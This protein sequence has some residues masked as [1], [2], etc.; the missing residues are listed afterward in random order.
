MSRSDG[1]PRA[2]DIDLQAS[3]RALSH[4]VV[5]FIL[6]ED[7]EA[8]VV[9]VRPVPEL[10]VPHAQLAGRRVVGEDEDI[11]RV[12]VKGVEEAGVEAQREGAHPV[13]RMHDA[14]HLA[15]VPDHDVG[16]LRRV[17]VSGLAPLLGVGRHER[18]AFDRVRVSDGPPRAAASA[19][20]LVAL[21]VVVVVPG[22]VRRLVRR[23]AVEE[24]LGDRE[25]FA[26][27]LFAHAVA[28]DHREA[29][30]AERLVPLGGRG[31]P[32]GLGE[33]L[34]VHE[35]CDVDGAEL[36]HHRRRSS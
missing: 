30:G 5:S 19:Y 25:D 33:A 10:A 14:L 27:E 28:L 11:G 36:P 32:R 21:G 2:F 7:R 3:H 18:V 24:R 9:A 12:H 31:C 34:R 6:E 1:D 22:G 13:N 8:G 16:Q 4:V 15:I 20:P 35:G 26:L 23:A 17:P 29:D